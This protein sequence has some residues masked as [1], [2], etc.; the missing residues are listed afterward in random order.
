MMWVVDTILFLWMLVELY[1]SF[2]VDVL[3]PTERVFVVDS[4]G[5][6]CNL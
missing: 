2:G 6:D 3:V 1:H 5:C 4:G